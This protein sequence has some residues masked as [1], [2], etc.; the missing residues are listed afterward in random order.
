MATT[1]LEQNEALVL[2]AFEA[3]FNKDDCAAA[4]SET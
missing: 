2:N 3:L 1:S 4:E